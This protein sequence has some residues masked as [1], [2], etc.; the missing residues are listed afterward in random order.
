MKGAESRDWMASR[1]AL[2]KGIISSS[3]GKPEPIDI[4]A[5]I[6]GVWPLIGSYLKETARKDE[7]IVFWY[8]LPLLN[9]IAT[10]S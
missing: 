6:V 7:A 8:D 5:N 2:Q 1:P 3:L 4:V 9:F 10:V